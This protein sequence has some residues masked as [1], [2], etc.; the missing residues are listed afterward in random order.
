MCRETEKKNIIF[1]QRREGGGKGK[2]A[3]KR[4]EFI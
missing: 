4:D 1:R 3:G 2:L